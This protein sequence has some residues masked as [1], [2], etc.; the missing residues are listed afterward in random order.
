MKDYY[1]YL[2]LN[3]NKP[4]KSKIEKL[5]IELEF[6][7]IYVGKG[8]KDRY[9]HHIK[10]VTSDN[11]VNSGNKLK[12][13]TIL[14][15]LKNT[16]IEKYKNEYIIKVKEN[17]SNE[18]ALKLEYDIMV[19]YGT[20]LDIEND[21]NFGPLTNMSVCGK[22]NPVLNG[23]NNPMYG[24][25]LFNIWEEKYG[26]NEA[27]KRLEQLKHTLSKSNTKRWEKFKTTDD[28]IYWKENLSE[29]LKE[30]HAKRKYERNI[31]RLSSLLHLNKLKIDNFYGLNNEIYS[32][33]IS[34]FKNIDQIIKI[35][36]YLFIE[37]YTQ[38]AEAL[39]YKNSKKNFYNRWIC[40]LGIDQASE[41]IKKYQNKIGD[42]TKR[43][44]KKEEYREKRARSLQQYWKN[45]SSEERKKQSKNKQHGW[46]KFKNKLGESGYED[47]LNGHVRGKNNPMYG[48]GHK[49]KGSKNGKAQQW[50]IHTPEGSKYYCDGTFTKFKKEVLRKYKPQPHR[51]YFKEIIE[52]D[53]EIE[54]WYFKK[55]DK[56]FNNNEYKKYE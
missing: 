49:L 31:N 43:L 35:K 12:H 27:N 9:L 53:I 10:H 5:G 6:E 4:E 48:Q 11:F 13:N 42:N 39:L 3:P 24:K 8:K 51:K 38:K 56:N 21:E 17:L 7:P 55:V 47:Y 25:P 29:R 44:W 19:Q 20:V 26:E 23:K 52:K 15:I 16:D 50:I 45:L 36:D 1:V 2:Y 28:F 14:K 41:K 18:E 32:E 30:I 40:E 22:I 34:H 37:E 33:F 46:K 54:G